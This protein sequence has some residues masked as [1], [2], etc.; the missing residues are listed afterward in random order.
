VQPGRAREQDGMA[1]PATAP[2]TKNA[3]VG[4]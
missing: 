4:R 1:D 3:Q 2:G